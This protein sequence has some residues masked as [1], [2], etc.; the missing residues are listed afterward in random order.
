MTPAADTVNA[1]LGDAGDRLIALT[2]AISTFG[3]LDLTM[4]APTRVYYAMAADGLFFPSVARLHPK[5]QTPSLAIV[6]QTGWAILLLLTGGYAQLVDYVVFADWIFFG[7]AAASLFVFRRRHPLAER[8]EGTYATPGY[9]ILPALF[10]LVAVWIV[11]SVLWTN[12][13]RSGLGVAILAT[14]V[15]AYL[16]WNRRKDRRP[17]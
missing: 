14:G 11:A 1:L 8:P 3:F 6:I 13:V 12:P 17:V 10:V 5:Y 7:L 2:I 15:P 16:Y 4:L 9:P